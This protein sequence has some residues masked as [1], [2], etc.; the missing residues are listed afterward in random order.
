[1]TSIH[2]WLPPDTSIKGQIGCGVYVGGIIVAL[3]GEG[4]SLQGNRCSDEVRVDT[5]IG[6]T[7]G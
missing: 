1:M 7:T 3:S 6:V 4:L 5:I 2:T